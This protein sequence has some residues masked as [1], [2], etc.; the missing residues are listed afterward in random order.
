M[1][2]SQ[3]VIQ[4]SVDFLDS[5]VCDLDMKPMTPVMTNGDKFMPSKD[6]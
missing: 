3:V 2:Y 6:R 5:V 4:K 1:D